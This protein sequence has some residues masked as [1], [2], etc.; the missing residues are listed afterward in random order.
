MIKKCEKYDI[1]N[2]NWI[3]IP[4]LNYAR[5]NTSLAVHNQRYLYCFCGYD[6]FRNVDTFE[7]L[8]FKHEK[9]GWELTE[10]KNVDKEMEVVDIRKNRMGIITLDFDRMLIFGGE[11]NNKEYKEAY[12]YE[13]FENKFY[14]FSDLVRTSNFIMCPVFHNGKYIT[15]DFLNNIHELNLE[16]LQFEYHVFHKEGENANV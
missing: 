15:F 9:K 16:S 10:L 11:R 2:D 1:F 14:P 5:Q 12:I 4:E 7:K 6:G 13:F 3:E 8:D